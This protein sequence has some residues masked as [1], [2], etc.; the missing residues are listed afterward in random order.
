[1]NG[2]V[3]RFFTIFLC[4]K[5]VQVA[6]ASIELIV[7]KEIRAIMCVWEKNQYRYFIVIVSF[8]GEIY[9]Q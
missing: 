4:L 1:M 6:T 5:F 9:L 3:E 2:D 8:I 7:R